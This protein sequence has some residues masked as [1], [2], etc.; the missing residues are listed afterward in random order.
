[1]ILQIQNRQRK[2]PAEEIRGLVETAIGKTL[3]CEK[4][5]AFL[6]KNKIEPVF[7]VTF[8][9][10]EGIRRLN[11]DYRHIDRATDVLSFPM[12]D[13]N[14]KIITKVSKK[15]LFINE[16]GE[17]ELNFGDIVLSIEKAK[18]QSEAYGH[19]LKREISFLT[20][21]SV[22][23]LI[24]YDHIEPDEEQKMIREQ[25]KIMKQ[26]SIKEMETL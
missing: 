26:W 23:H 17:K 12:I 15:D 16:K 19:S 20:V 11:C 7:S 22:L 24:G 14:G 21:H 13:N 2:Y 8:T 5:S 18:E 6:A 4:I 25:K 9:N 3:A 1:M 10:N